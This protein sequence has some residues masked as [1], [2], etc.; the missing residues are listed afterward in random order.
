M[1]KRKKNNIIL[2]MYYFFNKLYIIT[3]AR[4]MILKPIFYFFS[5]DLKDFSED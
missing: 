5:V 4:A 2:V 1:I 3:M